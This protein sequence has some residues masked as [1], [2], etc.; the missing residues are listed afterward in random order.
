MEDDAVVSR[1]TMLAAGAAG[2]AGVSAFGAEVPPAVAP[3]FS[4][5]EFGARGDGVADD[6][7]SVQAAVDAAVKAK[8]GR[9][10]FPSGSYRLTKTITIAS[11]DRLDLT[12]DGFSS[13]LLH[14]GPE[15][16]LA[17]QEG[18]ACRESSVRDLCIAA[19]GQSKDP[20]IAA[21]ACLG[22]VERSLFSHLLLTGGDIRMGSGILTRGVAD[23]TALI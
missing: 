17:W 16:C 11:S 14:A 22:G 4:V 8:G 2:L 23:T 3:V 15:H 7:E 6:T 19:A 20:G 13:V 10:H 1:R 9:V 12:G 5:R 18:S 21:I